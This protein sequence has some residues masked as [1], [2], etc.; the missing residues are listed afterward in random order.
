M[1]IVYLVASTKEISGGM[2]VIFEHVNQLARYGHNVEVWKANEDDQ[3]YFECEVPIRTYQD[4]QLNE[5]DVVV[6]TDC[7]F[8]PAVSIHRKRRGTY[9]L[10]QHDNEWVS[11][12]M[13]VA[14]YA[15]L[16]KEYKSYFESGNCEI[17]VVSSWLQ[18]LVQ[19]KYALDSHIILNGVDGNLFHPV[20]PILQ[21][22]APLALLFYD[23]Q[24]WKGFGEAIAALL[25]VKNTQENLQI[26]IIGRYFPET[27]QVEGMSFGFPFPAIYFNRP[28]QQDLAKIYSSA[29][30]FVSASWK[31][32][33]GLPGLEAMACGVPVVTTDAGGNREYAVDEQTALI[34]P[35]QNITAMSDEILRILSDDKLHERLRRNGLGKAKGLTWDKSIKKL[36]GIFES[37]ILLT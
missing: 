29:D 4:E 20:R 34:V 23:P 28:K 6:M 25:E 2:R 5:P 10:L 17:I 35:Q 14:T 33:F 13:N 22:D 27:P 16:I 15:G 30:V 1:K 11:E 24:S 32:G 12:V 19:E 37:S 18:A 26:A 8:I 21:L 3:P 36:E 9:L 7:V 31:E